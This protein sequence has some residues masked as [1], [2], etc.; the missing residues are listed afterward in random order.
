M[1]TQPP[2]QIFDFRSNE[3]RAKLLSWRKQEATA[4]K[5]LIFT[6]GVF[7]ILHR[8]HVE[9]LSKAALLGDLLIVGLNTDESVRRLKGKNRPIQQEE[10][11]AIILGSLKFVDA[12]VYFDEDTPLELITFL[13]PDILTKGADYKIGDIVGSD[14]IIANGGKV[15]T[16]DL[17]EGRS[18]SNAIDTIVKRYEKR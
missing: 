16:I 8:G 4:G 13:L 2:A 3:S 17:T 5:K 6:N 7:D 11:R 12:L 18:T 14:V 15:L 1:S 9:Y 10:D